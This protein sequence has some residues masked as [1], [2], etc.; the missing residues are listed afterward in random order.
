MAIRTVRNA[1]SD[2][3]SFSPTRTGSKPDLRVVYQS[4]F[5][6]GKAKKRSRRN[7]VNRL[8]SFSR[9][10]RCRTFFTGSWIR[11]RKNVG[12]LWRNRH[13]DLTRRAGPRGARFCDLGPRNFQADDAI[14]PRTL[15][16]ILDRLTRTDEVAMKRT[17]TL[18]FRKEESRE[19][20]L[21]A[22]QQ[23]PQAHARFP[24][25]HADQGRAT[26]TSTPSP[27]GT[28][29]PDRLG[30]EEVASVLV[31]ARGSESL[32]RARRLRKRGHFL[33]VQSRGKKLHTAHF[34]VFIQSQPDPLA[35]PRLGVTVSRKIGTA[36][37]RNRVKRLVREVFRRCQM[38]FPRGVDVVF[39]AKRSAAGV[40][41]EEVKEELVALCKRAFTS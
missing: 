29:A 32:P 20:H 39:V 38:F 26:D 37:I 34:L 7:T 41:Y 10:S 9:R 6:A 2:P 8:E 25:A 40:G 23:A 17:L 13:R 4:A 18:A 36:V 31:S 15:V 3:R 19:A 1:R 14:A 33:S 11:R 22:P 12:N 5:W 24:Q 28:Q 27:E 21:S 16:R 30:R 35:S